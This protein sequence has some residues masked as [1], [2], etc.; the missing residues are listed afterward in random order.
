MRGNRI[1]NAYFFL[2]DDWRLAR[3][4]TLNLGLRYEGNSGVSEVNGLLSNLDLNRREAQGGAGAGPLGSF[5]TGDSYFRPTANWGPRFGFA[6]NPGRGRT[7]V[8]GGYGIAYDFLYLN[9]VTNGRFLPPFMYNFTLPSTEIAG[10][11]SYARLLAGSSDFQ[12]EGRAAV[13]SFPAGM[14]N[15]GA[16]TPVDRGLK[17]PQ[18]QQFSFSVDRELPWLLLGRLAY[19]GTKGNFLQRSRPVNPIAPGIFTPPSTAQEE[20]ARQA[21]GEFIRM[22]AALNAPFSGRTNRL[23][24]RFNAVTLVDSSANSVYHSLQLQVSRRFSRGYGFTAAYTFSKSIDDVSDALAVLAGDTPSQQNPF[25]NRNN[26]ALSQF[27]VPHRFVLLHGFEPRARARNPFARALFQGWMLS[28]I[29]QAQTGFPVNL[30]GGARAGLADPTLLGANGSVR[31]NLERPLRLD[32]E[33]NPGLGARNP[34]KAAP[35]G[36]GQPLVGAF[37]TLGRNVVRVNPLVQY[38]AALGKSFRRGETTTLQFQVQFEN[39]FNNTTFS[40]PG[41]TLSA[42]ATFGYY[43]DT[44][45]NPRNATFILRLVW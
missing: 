27:D 30:L 40:R 22:N 9:P 23:D 6:W 16:V 1:A 29:F 3:T 5:Y 10:N 4:L 39:L 41:L 35:S 37:G 18:V 15:F 26:R 32:F 20:Q 19:S 43:A 25:D 13:G 42:P 17:N 14:R 45:S 7:V 8:R 28:G 44:D 38:D 36:L 33:A 21:S 2:Q 34:N 31:P 12:S 24:P 11:N